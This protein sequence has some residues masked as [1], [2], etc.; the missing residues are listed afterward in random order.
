MDK[1]LKRLFDY[2][3][4]E[5]NAKLKKQLLESETLLS[6]YEL[7]DAEL[8]LAYGGYDDNNEIIDL[9]KIGMNI[10]Y[11][12]LQSTSGYKEEYGKINSIPYE[13]NGKLYV[14]VLTS[15]N[16]KIKV[17]LADIKII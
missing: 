2:Q 17:N 15:S 5:G 12:I 16:E 14:D 6:A 10:R 9:V 4:F 1:K 11:R 3:K 13:N 8:S 7:S